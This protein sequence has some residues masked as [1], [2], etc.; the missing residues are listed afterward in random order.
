MGDYTAESVFMSGE[1]E[2]KVCLSLGIFQKDGTK[3]FAW[4]IIVWERLENSSDWNLTTREF[5]D[6][7]SFVLSRLKT[8]IIMN[9][10][11]SFDRD[12]SDFNHT[13]VRPAQKL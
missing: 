1:R 9:I 3:D 11:K 8:T 7:I 4:N 10:E 6:N 13:V 5:P 2:Y 12:M